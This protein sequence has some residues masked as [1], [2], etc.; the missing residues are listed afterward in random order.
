MIT[1]TATF[2]G[3]EYLRVS[4]DRSDFERSN[5]D[6]HED[7]TDVAGEF[8]IALGTAYRDVGS[9]SRFNPKERDDFVRLMAD[10]RD[11]TFSADVLQMWENSRGSRKPREWLDLIDACQAAGVKILITTSRRLY[12]LN[13][14][15]DRHALQED[16][17]KAAAASEETSERVTRTLNR[18]AE[19]GKPHGLIPYGFRRTYSKVRNTKGRLVTRPEAQLPDPAEALHVIDLFVKLHDGRSFVSIE[20]DWAAR[21]IVSRDS[22]P[23]SAQS[24]SQMARKVSYIGKRVRTRTVEDPETG[25]RRKTVIGEIDAAWPVIADFDGSPMTPEDFVTLFHEVQIIL[26][27][28]QRRTNPGGGAKHE[29]TMTIRCDVCGGP[30]TVTKH[31][32]AEGEQVYACRDKGC[33]RLSEKAE[34]DSLLTRIVLAYLARPDS[35]DRRFGTGADDS[36]ELGVVRAQLARKRAA[37]TAFEAEDPETPAEARVIGRKIEKL[38]TEIRE[39]AD[40]ESGLTAPNPLETLFPQGAAETVAAR[41]KATELPARRAVAALLLTPELL[42][43][44][45]VRRVADSPSEA[46]QDRLNWV[47]AA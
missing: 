22:V 8:G 19:K 25:K 33:V 5:E 17:L 10:L 12:D 6:Q 37:L 29:Y 26:S 11:G 34:L 40:R 30:I 46:V 4:F 31:L 1:D 28:P 41:W 32:S 20:A 47:T 23:F 43:Q 18:N 13:Q 42:G 39:L 16:S 35:Y 38:E 45:R 7:N 2:T 44:V 14:W 27:D 36:A 24:L 21:G 9:A 15:R 3:R